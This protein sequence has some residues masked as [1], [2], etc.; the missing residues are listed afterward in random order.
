[1]TR[2]RRDE[3]D[4]LEVLRKICTATDANIGDIM[5]LLSESTAEYGLDTDEIV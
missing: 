5:E 2:L 3:E 4:T 1:M